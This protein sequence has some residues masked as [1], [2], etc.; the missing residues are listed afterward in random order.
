MPIRALLLD[1]DGTLADSL[2]AL[3][4]VYERFV[5]DLG[6]KPNGDEFDAL[7]GPPLRDVVES[8]CMA[9]QSRAH[10]AED[11]DRYYRLIADELVRIEPAAGA[12]EL[13]NAARSRGIATAIVTSSKAELVWSWLEAVGLHFDLIVAGDDI[14]EGKPSPAPYTMALRKLGVVPE[15]ALAIEDSPSGIRSAT[16]AGIR[17]LRLGHGVSTGAEE[18]CIASLEDAVAYVQAEA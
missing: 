3:R 2:P 5:I 6:A 4:R 16:A 7:N 11:L 17:T 18:A 14:A 1:F 12:S 10:A 13:L 9:H 15:Q 8:L